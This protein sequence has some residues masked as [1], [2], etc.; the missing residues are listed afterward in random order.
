MQPTAETPG[1]KGSPPSADVPSELGRMRIIDFAREFKEKEIERW[2]RSS[3]FE[4]VAIA[5][6]VQAFDGHGQQFRDELIRGFV[7]EIKE[8]LGVLDCEGSRAMVDSV[9]EEAIAAARVA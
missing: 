9:G 7:E 6:F 1:Q 5:A 2:V 3:L 8:Q 4:K